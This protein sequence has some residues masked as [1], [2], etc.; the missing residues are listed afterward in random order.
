MDEKF[1]EQIL[2]DETWG[3]KLGGGGQKWGQIFLKLLGGNVGEQV[4]KEKRF[5]GSK[6]WGAF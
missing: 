5:L 2:S 3:A 4:L 6:I 1:G